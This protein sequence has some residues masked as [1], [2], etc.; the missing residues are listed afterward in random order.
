MLALSR[1]EELELLA[2]SASQPKND[3]P[4]HSAI[5]YNIDNDEQI[6][7]KWLSYDVLKRKLLCR[8]CGCYGANSTNDFVVGLGDENFR[9][10]SQL[11]RGHESSQLH[12]EASDTYFRNI[13]G[14]GILFLAAGW[15][16]ASDKLSRQKVEKN[17]QILNR[18]ID[19]IK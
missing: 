9:R 18:I 12:C 11:V 4:F 8:V 3:I 13:Q 1:K 14:K 19:I 16:T 17:S 6:Q 5:Y 15:K 10:A 2:S 7:R